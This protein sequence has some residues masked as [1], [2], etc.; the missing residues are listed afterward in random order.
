[1]PPPPGWH[2]DLNFIL[3]FR[4][5]EL[6]EVS[7]CRK[8]SSKQKFCWTSCFAHCILVS[9][10][11]W[12]R[13]RELSGVVMLFLLLVNPFNHAPN[14]RGFVWWLVLVLDL[15]SLFMSEY[16]ACMYLCTLCMCLVPE[17][18]SRRHQIPGTGTAEPP[19]GCWEQNCGPPQEQMHLTT[20]PSLQ[21]LKV[22]LNLKTMP[23]DPK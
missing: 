7:K 10:L 20:E 14:P 4:K 23:V 21:P 22:D 6:F 19:Y 15:F 17:D 2:F 12:A 8:G 3:N 11:Y 18:V 9:V 5:L 1:M 13:Q 16:F